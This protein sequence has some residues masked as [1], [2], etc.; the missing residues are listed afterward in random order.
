M[1]LSDISPVGVPPLMQGIG[2]SGGGAGGGGSSAQALAIGQAQRLAQGIAPRSVPS[3]IYSRLP[4][5]RNLSPEQLSA[6]WPGA[7]EV[8]IGGTDFNNVGTT[9]KSTARTTIITDVDPFTG[10]RTRREIVVKASNPRK[11]E[12]VFRDSTTGAEGFVLDLGKLI[13]D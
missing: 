12:T 6:G 9:K 4:G 10:K 7:T 11:G 1:I 13:Q 2:Q 8:V 3:G 5:V